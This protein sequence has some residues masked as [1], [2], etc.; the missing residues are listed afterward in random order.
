MLKI[1]GNRPGRQHM[2]LIPEPEHYRFS[3]I[4]DYLMKS[5]SGDFSKLNLGMVILS[6]SFI[7]GGTLYAISVVFAQ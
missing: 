7:S 1:Q 5:H 3:I 2:L 4:K 6:L